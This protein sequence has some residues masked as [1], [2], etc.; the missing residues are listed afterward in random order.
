MSKKLPRRKPP[1]LETD[2]GSTES[3]NF[4]GTLFTLP[5][6][7]SQFA[8]PIPTQHVD[9]ST[10][11]VDL[12]NLSTPT[13]PSYNDT[14]EISFDE[15]F[16]SVDSPKPKG[17][18]EIWEYDQ[19][20]FNAIPKDISSRPTHAN[21]QIS[22]ILPNRSYQQMSRSQSNPNMVKSTSVES[23]PP[24]P[25][26]VHQVEPH[27]PPYPTG[28]IEDFL[29]DDFDSEFA[30]DVDSPSQR[31]TRAIIEETVFT[32][33]PKMN[34][35]PNLSTRSSQSTIP[36]NHNQRQ[37]IDTSFT[38]SAGSSPT[39]TPNHRTSMYSYFP[40]SNSQSRS[41]SPKRSIHSNYF[42]SS[43]PVLMVNDHAEENEAQD[44]LYSKH[45]PVSPYRVVSDNPFYDEQ[46]FYN[47]ESPAT[48]YF[49]YSFL[50]ELPPSR[51][52][53][54]TSSPPPPPLP[55]GPPPPLPKKLQELPPLPLDLPQL[56]FSSSALQAQH[57]E[58]CSSVWSLSNLFQWCCKLQI[59]LSD[60][61]ISKSEL[62]KAIT[63]LIAFHRSDVSLDVVIHNAQTAFN[64][65][66]QAQA[67]KVMELHRPNA[68]GDRSVVIFDDSAYV[69]GVL[70]ELSQCF[71]T[72]THTKDEGM[73]CYST[74]CPFSRMM[75]LE[76]KMRSMNIK[77]IVL[78][79]DWAAHWRLTVDDL[80]DLDTNMIKRQ[81]LI[82][83]LLRYE[84]TFIQR[85]R[86]FVDVV[87]P[88]FVKAAKG[89][90]GS[91]S[92]KIKVFEDEVIKTGAS[93]V[94]IHQSQL[95]EPL[96]KVLI[97]E[98]KF[99]KNVIEIVN[100]YTDWA[101]QVRPY[102]VTYM[103]NMPMIEE[104]LSI[105]SL[106]TYVDQ[107]IGQLP[108]VKE[109]RVNVPILFI[110]TFN[111][112]Y[113]QIPLQLLDIQKRFDRHE[114]EYF[115]LQQASDEIKKLGSKINDS[116]KLADNVHALEQLKTQLY[117]KSSLRQRNLNL[118]SVNRKLI[119]R[120]DL[121]RR[122]DLKI[123][124]QIN[125]V[126][127]L[128]NVILITER[129][130]TPKPNGNQYKICEDPIPIDF[131]IF[132]D[133]VM[134]TST[135][136]LSSSPITKTEEED[137]TKYGVKLRYAGRPRHSYLFICKTERE[138]DDWIDYLTT[139]RA[140][141]NKRL[142]NTK[143][144][145]GKPISTTCFAYELNNRI[146]KLPVV[147]P[148][149]TIY[150]LYKESVEKAQ[151]LGISDIYSPQ[152]LRSRIVHSSIQCCVT[153][154][155]MDL[156]FTFVGLHS[157]LYCCA[158]RSRWKKLLHGDF[159]KVHVDTSI[160]LVVILS[161][162]TLRYYF[163]RQLLDVY[164]GTRSEIAGITLSKEPV[165]FFSMKTH[166]NVPM[167]FVAKKKLNITSFK[168]LIP[169]TDNNGVF[170][171]FKDDRKFY[172]EAECFGISIFNSSFALHTD[173][174]FEVME[175]DKL[176]PRSVPDL[177][178]AETERKKLDQFSRKTT[179]STMLET[180][181]KLVVSPASIPMGMFKLN[182]G[183]EF[184]LVYSEFAIFIDKHGKLSRE[185]T[186]L[187]FDFKAQSIH[188]VDN[189]LFLVR[190]DI[191]EVLSISD[192]SKGSNDLVQLI[193]GKGIKLVSSVEERNVTLAMANP[194][195]CGLQLLFDLVS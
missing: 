102:L 69:N 39:C 40:E 180:I 82:F 27:N 15:S 141:M 90:L 72:I 120:G 162:K 11:T 115:L 83:D 25:V 23:T 55:T 20:H 114:P 32:T 131:L 111:S 123:T 8:R 151:T 13:E 16:T 153:F 5:P 169:E 63:R 91:N 178:R 136:K 150:S 179:S 46:E 174:G 113:Q 194:R 108:R 22:R 34:D 109:L 35:I 85:A 67:I 134:S 147:V 129:L 158:S 10:N 71:T 80:R 124:S 142:S 65:F 58:T 95:F 31:R 48:D 140:N 17:P 181:K 192:F 30:F 14:T 87:G 100:I 126:I 133:R 119:C 101:K 41:P 2:A 73:T 103:N 195:V 56:P 187:L 44:S 146:T 33:S 3:S 125:H 172:I 159:T 175:L 54:S 97:S 75:N 38:D 186:A 128:D 168:V 143:L 118:G 84:Q 18:K 149:D 137:T 188:F 166:K 177:P 28:P 183:T 79:T 66:L 94:D 112:R 50:P 161:D 144:Y 42:D 4:G 36:I 107:R 176:M 99:I 76:R 156:K 53:S 59:W 154:E 78:A 185:K 148:N 89:F 163:L 132:E 130:K 139:A 43:K 98:G 164:T 173:K 106:K 64:S 68:N 37:S 165:L 184:L 45:H 92:S 70:P 52:I 171:R 24:Y 21:I 189:H 12:L 62:I 152:I 117:W 81:S 122:G 9:Y 29:D 61:T 127:I 155:L 57:F 1:P 86:C 157:G 167:L 145:R 47:F 49:D 88:S 105:P 7:S 116:K 51:D 77:D 104:L 60:S 182:N 74:I 96:L 190:D 6:E 19:T 138:K 170:C 160:G 93:I 193:T 121:S 135:I 26:S 191:V 110:S